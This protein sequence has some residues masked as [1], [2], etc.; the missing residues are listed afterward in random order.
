ME[1]YASKEQAWVIQTKSYRDPPC[2][3]GHSHEF[4]A[5]PLNLGSGKLAGPLK[6]CWR[7]NATKGTAD[8]DWCYS[9]V[10]PS[11]PWR[12]SLWSQDPWP[13][14]VVP[15]L[16]GLLG[17]SV[18]MLGVD[19]LHIFHLGVGRDLCGSA[20][21]ILV[22]KRGYWRGRNQEERLKF[23]TQRLKSYA[24]Q[25]GY[26]LTMSKLS[27]QSLNWKADAYPEL[28]AKGFDCF[29]VLRWL[30]SEIDNKD[31]GNDTLATDTWFGKNQ[32]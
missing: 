30:I 17:F 25:H 3:P 21:R 7:C 10:S 29:V 23:A 14:N 8:V 19:L 31:I 22:T 2:R 27:K 12:G 20:V 28:K 13:Q 32:W 18:R 6:V 26:S 9:N 4:L 24:K 15:S 11:A 16:T 1:R 5:N